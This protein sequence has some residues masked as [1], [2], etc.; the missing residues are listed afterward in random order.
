M[1]MPVAGGVDPVAAA[2]KYVSTLN[3]A[4]RRYAGTLQ[5]LADKEKGQ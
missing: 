5:A 4:V 2:Q 3:E 1:L